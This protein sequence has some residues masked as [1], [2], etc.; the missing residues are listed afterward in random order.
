MTEDTE[1]LEQPIIGKDAPRNSAGLSPGQLKAIEMIVEGRTYKEIIEE[2]GISKTSLAKWRTNKNF[3]KEL[4]KNRKKATKAAQDMA[5]TNASYALQR[6]VEIID[7]KDATR[8]QLAA[9][10]KVYEY[11]TG[12][13][14]QEFEERIEK[15]E[16]MVT[17]Q[18]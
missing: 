14:I 12:T 8:T 18:V 17:R 1:I 10:V 7:D 9:A 16:E 2:V 4:S 15:L 3:V 13:T 5:A 11:G 6:I